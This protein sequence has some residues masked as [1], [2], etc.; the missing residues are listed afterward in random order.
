MS[1]LVYSTND[2]VYDFTDL[3]DAVTDIFDSNTGIN[4]TTIYEVQS[5]TRVEQQASDF[6]RAHIVD[7]MREIAYEQ[8]GEWAEDYLS[9]SVKTEN[10]LIDGF[11]ILVN[12]WA[13][14]HKLHPTFYKVTDIKNIRFRFTRISKVEYEILGADNE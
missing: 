12:E 1:D 13:T 2:E 9:C 3:Y 7:D 6:L 4:L 10:E 14:T 5:G 11:K 8:C